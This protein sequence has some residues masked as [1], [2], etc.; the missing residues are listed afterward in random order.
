MM[1]VRPAQNWEE[2]NLIVYQFGMDLYFATIKPIEPKQELKVVN[3]FSCNWLFCPLKEICK[4][5]INSK[6]GEDNV[7]APRLPLSAKFSNEFDYSS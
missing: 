4:L 2:Q 3:H 1:F 7:L 6:S 5:N